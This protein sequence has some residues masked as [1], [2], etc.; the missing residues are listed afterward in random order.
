MR[1]VQQQTNKEWGERLEKIMQRPLPAMPFSG[2]PLSEPLKTA[3][4]SQ[5][6]G[7]GPVGGQCAPTLSQ[8]TPQYNAVGL[9]AT[10]PPARA[11][12]TSRATAAAS[13]LSG[14][15]RAPASEV[16]DEEEVD[17]AGA[18]GGVKI[19]ELEDD[20]IPKKGGSNGWV[21]AAYNICPP[22]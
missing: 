2:K 9:T 1:G 12:S 20:E 10:A 18:V 3:Q 19:I 4:G 5:P 15:T 13:A 14:R 11:A 17:T 6:A 16:G 8:D 21:A 22:C 7:T